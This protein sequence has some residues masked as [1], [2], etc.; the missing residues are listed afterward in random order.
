MDDSRLSRLCVTGSQAREDV[1][2]PRWIPTA[3]LEATFRIAS[4]QVLNPVAGRYCYFQFFKRGLV[5]TVPTG[6]C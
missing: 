4:M 6:R 1:G 3:Y 5:F 2:P